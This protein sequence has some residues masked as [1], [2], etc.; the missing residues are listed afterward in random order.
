MDTKDTGNTQ[1]TRNYHVCLQDSVLLQ[2]AKAK[3]GVGNKTL[4]TEVR[5]I[6][7]SGSQR[8]YLTQRVRNKLQLP[9]G[10]TESLRIKT[11]GECETEL[12]AASCET[13][14]LAVGD[15][16]GRTRT[17]VEAF[18]VP[19]ICL[20]LARLDSQVKRL[21]QEPSLFEE[22]NQICE[23]QLSQGIVEK[24]E[25]SN[26]DSVPGTTHYLP[27]QVVV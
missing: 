21:R 14:N 8:S 5:V 15:I 22:Y 3:V 20:S 17:Q 7:Y 16:T 13:V 1:E 19:V 24:V 12:T 9:I 10:N 4:S 2:T 27:H 11:F 26:E 6:F 25:D 23:E 18:V